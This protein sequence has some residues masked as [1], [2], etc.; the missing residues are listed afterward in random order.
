MAEPTDAAESARERAK[1]AKEREI[2][3]HLAAA[4]QQEEAALLQDRLGHPDRAAAARERAARARQA[5]V[6]AVGEI[7]EDQR[8]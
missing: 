7:P 1:R 4:Q 2:R 8:P 6:D 5:S 3:T